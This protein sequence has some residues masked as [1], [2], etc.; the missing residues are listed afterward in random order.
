MCLVFQTKYKDAYVKDI[1]GHYVGSPE[2]PYHAH[3]MK[4][5]AQNS[6]VSSKTIV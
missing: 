6:D 3:C 5:A 1:L 2:D 4:I